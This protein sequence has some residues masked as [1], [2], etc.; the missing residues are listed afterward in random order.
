MLVDDEIQV[1]TVCLNVSAW[2]RDYFLQGYCQETGTREDD[3]IFLVLSNNR[4]RGD[5]CTFIRDS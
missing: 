2:N 5:V 4:R 1:V 3:G